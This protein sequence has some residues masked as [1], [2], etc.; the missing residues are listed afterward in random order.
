ME[1][2][3]EQLHV[4]LFPNSKTFTPKPFLGEACVFTPGNAE[5]CSHYKYERFQSCLA[6]RSLSRSS[7]CKMRRSGSSMCHEV[8]A[9]MESRDVRECLV[10]QKSVPDIA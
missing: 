7:R 4:S 9:L 2:S 10:L 5:P 6:S 8:E 3:S 1:A